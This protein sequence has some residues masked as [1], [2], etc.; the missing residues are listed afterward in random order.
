MT[1][2]PVTGNM[3]KEGTACAGPLLGGKMKT[4]TQIEIALITQRGRYFLKIGKVWLR[5]EGPLLKVASGSKQH[6][7]WV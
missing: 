7:L 5:G 4:I 1:K 6:L 3:I 2:F